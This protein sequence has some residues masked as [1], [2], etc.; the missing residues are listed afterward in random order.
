MYAIEKADKW[1]WRFGA[2]LS[3][4]FFQDALEWVATVCFF[5]S[6]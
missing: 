6:S 4:L 3:T 2:S 5:E 1:N